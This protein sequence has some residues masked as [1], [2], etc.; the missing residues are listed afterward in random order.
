MRD[1]VA[2]RD[3][4]SD[5]LSNSGRRC[6]VEPIR[7]LNVV[8]RAIRGRAARVIRAQAIKKIV[9]RPILLEDDHHMLEGAS[10]RVG[11]ERSKCND[12]DQQGPT[13]RTNFPNSESGLQRFLHLVDVAGRFAVI[14]L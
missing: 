13:Q 11:G 10:L 6:R 4:N 8:M 1:A 2:T 14:H 7:K 12:Q 9:R 3:G 5:G